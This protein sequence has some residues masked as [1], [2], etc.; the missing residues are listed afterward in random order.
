MAATVAHEIRN[1]LGG[2]G[3]FARL[4]ERDLEISDPRRQLAGRIIEGVG[5]LNKIVSNLL[6]YTRPMETH[7]RMVPIRQWL[8]D[9]GDWCQ[10]EA[11]GQEVK[12]LDVAIDV[13]ERIENGRFDPEKL[14][15]VMFNLLL[16]AL[17]SME[18]TGK[19]RLSARQAPGLLILGVQDSGKGI[20]PELVSEIFNPFF[21][22]KESGTGLGLAIVRKIVELHGGN[23][24]VHSQ[25]GQGTR[26]DI[27]L[28]Q[29]N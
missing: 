24:M 1:P 14:Q 2:I 27:H 6:T 9:L 21:T 7:Y 22:T 23:L 11:E 17:Q 15:Q 25:P 13:D 19:L 8:Q 28:P 29:A 5:S 4:L 10:L 20:P 18:G 12:Q 16:N 3:G 26:F